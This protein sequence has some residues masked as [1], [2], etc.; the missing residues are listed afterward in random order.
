MNTETAIHTTDTLDR[1]ALDDRWLGFGYL[2]G[3]RHSNEEPVVERADALALDMANAAGLTYDE[4]FMWAN[5]KDAR[6]FADCAIGSDDLTMARRYGPH[7]KGR[8]CARRSC[9]H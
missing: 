7:A 6:W 2:Q 4:F 3:R 8:D 1:M 5:N 9:V